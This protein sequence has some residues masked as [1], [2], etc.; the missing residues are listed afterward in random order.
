MNLASKVT[1]TLRRN[2][3]D[4]GVRAKWAWVHHVGWDKAKE[5]AKEMGRRKAS[6]GHRV[7]TGAVYAEKDGGCWPSVW[8][9][10]RRRMWLVRAGSEMEGGTVKIKILLMV[11]LKMEG[12]ET[13]PGESK[14]FFS[15][16]FVRFAAV[17][18][19]TWGLN[20]CFWDRFLLH[21]TVWPETTGLLGFSCLNLL[22]RWTLCMSCA[23][24]SSLV[25]MEKIEHVCLHRH[26]CWRS[27]V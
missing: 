27:S 21:H 5:P 1:N 19:F 6:K 13:W 26:K 24:P 23:A 3:R 10:R 7:V 2:A 22:L 4:L 15:L 9:H 16:F 25:Q 18:W 20:F 17:S 8:Q 12:R 11:Y 14:D